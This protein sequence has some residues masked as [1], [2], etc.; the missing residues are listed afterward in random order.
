M[1][2]LHLTTSLSGGAGV[3][4]SRLAEAQRHDSRTTVRILTPREQDP[5]NGLD[6]P[7]VR[8]VD[9]KSKVL[10]ALQQVV[11]RKAIHFVSPMSASR[12]DWTYIESFNPDVIHIH[13]WYNLLSLSDMS[14]LLEDHKVVFTA[15]DERLLTGGCHITF[16]CVQYLESCSK[17]PQV[18]FGTGLISRS[19]DTLHQLLLKSSRYSIIAP[20]QWL[21]E[22]FEAASFLNQ[23]TKVQ[24][25]PNI[26]PLDPE[27]NLSEAIDP[28]IKFLF[29]TASSISSN[30]GLADVVDAIA[31]LS[32]IKT[33]LKFELEIAGVK[34]L[35][36]ETNLPNFRLK[37]LGILNETKM[38]EA[39]SRTHALI[40]A[41]K[42][43]NSPN[44]IPEAQLQGV[45]VIARAV[46][47]IPEI[48]QDRENG[49][50]YGQNEE[51]LLSMLIKFVEVPELEKIRIKR[52][53]RRNAIERHNIAGILEEN[54]NVYRELIGRDKR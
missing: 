2:I 26:I 12:L 10:T 50:L 20:S 47:G 1:K 54:L 53:A 36:V 34:S 23:T 6:S 22:K 18:R 19:A 37:C 9:I 45:I 48:I 3:A 40:V 39:Y 41:S 13:N 46:G 17:C 27:I 31:Q 52:Q 21:L 43:E 42:S 35:R 29:V 30:K 4:T 44:V 33:E 5:P 16:G 15:H 25:I 28:V 14:K 32:A 24:V 11:A 38:K 7:K 51:S 8:K 49:F